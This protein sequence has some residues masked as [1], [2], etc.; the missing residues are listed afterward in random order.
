MKYLVEVIEQG[1]KAA[2]DQKQLEAA[3][4]LA[5]GTITEVKAGRRGLPVEACYK[6]VDMTG[7]DL[8]RLIAESE[9]ITANPKKAEFWKKKLVEF[10]K[11]AAC[12]LVGVILN[13]TPTPSEAA[14][15]LDKSLI[16]LYIML[17][18]MRRLAH[19]KQRILEAFKV[20]IPETL[21]RFSIPRVHHVT[22]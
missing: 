1:A 18:C 14:P 4:D 5:R 8:A 11:L 17:N 12:V 22:A 10:E 15:M 7:A 19:L 21:L 2:G 9:A 3:L 20:C 16:T 6:L 13:M